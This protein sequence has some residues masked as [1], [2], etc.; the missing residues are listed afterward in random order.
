MSVTL[1]LKET[2]AFGRDPLKTS[3]RWRAEHGDF[4]RSPI[5]PGVEM[6]TLFDPKDIRQV[7]AT[8]H[9]SYRKDSWT[10]EVTD[11]LGNGLVTS[12]GDFWKKQRRLANPAFHKAAIDGYARTMV[13]ET[14]LRLESWPARSQ[15]DIADEMMRLTLDIAAKTLFGAQVSREVSDLIGQTIGFMMEDY[16][17]VMGTGVRLPAWLPTPHNFQKRR[18]LGR[19]HGLIDELIEHKRSEPDDGSLLAMLIRATYEDGTHMAAE[20]LRDEATT[21]LMAGHET[22]ANALIY[23]LYLL[24]LHPEVEERLHDEVDALPGVPTLA[25]LTQLTYTDQVICEVMRLY[26]PVWGIGREPLHDVEIRGEH[27][28]KGTQIYISQ[29][30]THRDP[31]FFDDPESFRPERW[32]PQMKKSLP[33]F[34]YFP[35]GGGPRICIGKR[36][37]QMEANLVLA[38]IAQRYAARL[39]PGE[40]LDLLPSVTL[41]PRDGLQMTVHSRASQPA[42]RVA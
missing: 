19:A 28:K 25:D 1:P 27:V 7:L 39:A 42:E 38:T 32:T 4:I 15:V 11:F 40:T 33:H 21:L 30:A 10:R 5:L 36:F 37:A 23:A 14:Q 9:R 24:S 3:E 35:Y 13:A 18:L 41:R 31:R 22:T 17:G 8:D 2:L 20:Q 34:A 26:P 12:E 6:V 29:W 16:Q